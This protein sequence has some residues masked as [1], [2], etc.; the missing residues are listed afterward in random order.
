MHQDA[1]LVPREEFTPR[2][3]RESADEGGSMVSRKLTT[4]T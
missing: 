3:K 4:G 2:A 1:L